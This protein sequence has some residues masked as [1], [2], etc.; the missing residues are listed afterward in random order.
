MFYQQLG[1]LLIATNLFQRNRSRPV[2]AN[3]LQDHFSWRTFPR[4]IPPD[5]WQVLAF[6]FQCFCL[7]LED[8]VDLRSLSSRRLS[9]CL[10]GTNHLRCLKAD[11]KFLYYP[12]SD[13]KFISTAWNLLLRLV[14]LLSPLMAR[15]TSISAFLP[16]NPCQSKF[17]SINIS[18]Y[19]LSFHFNRFL[20]LVS[21][22]L[23]RQNKFLL[24]TRNDSLEI[25]SKMKLRRNSRSLKIPQ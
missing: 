14:V 10:L 21:T 4:D 2:A 18:P 15:F 23:H 19:R 16:Q 22:I 11:N 7:S 8:L 13:F 5:W 9:G 1:R 3:L 6:R 20:S 24:R 12:K 25:L 17:R